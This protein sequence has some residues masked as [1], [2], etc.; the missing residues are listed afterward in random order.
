MGRPP[1][2]E[3]AY[4]PCLL[5][6]YRFCVL[7][8]YLALTGCAAVATH[9]LAENVS[10][11]ILNQNDPETV[12]AGAP[13]YLM[14]LDGL[15]EAS[16]NDPQLLIAGA[17][18]YDAYAA[19]FVEDPER[20]RRL[21]E[22]ARKY[23]RRA[24]CLRRQE[25]CSLERGPYLD[26]EPGLSL[27][28]P[29]DVPALYTYATTCAGWVRIDGEGCDGLAELPKVEAMLERVVELDEEFERGRAHAYLG[30]IRSRLPPS[31]G[32]RPERGREHFERALELAG[33]RDLIVKVEYA[34]RYARL[35][36]DR[37]L[38][39]RLLREVLEADLVE[40]G[41]TLS[42]VLAQGQARE[43]LNASE[44]YFYD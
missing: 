29:G 37:S 28:G 32:G 43:L 35:V 2:L 6:R 22:H 40:P 27:L 33:G 38:H 1:T 13:A 12:R 42:N 8:L 36:F 24:L 26:F 14:L 5:G 41:L 34:R 30:A 21:A 39:D 20:A 3:D 16:P 11:A 25:V 15:I 9:D 44:D 19:V 18:L 17:R 31:L 4:L 10:S 23:A 7:L